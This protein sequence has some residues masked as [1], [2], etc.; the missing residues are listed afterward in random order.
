MINKIKS[1]FTNKEE[2]EKI[3]EENKKNLKK[4]YEKKIEIEKK[5]Y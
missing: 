1:Y 4:D 2:I 5:R 3:H